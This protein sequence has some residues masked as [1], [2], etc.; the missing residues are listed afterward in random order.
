M[1]LDVPIIEII[2]NKVSVTELTVGRDRNHRE[3]HMG[4]ISDTPTL[5]KCPPSML[6]CR[7]SRTTIRT[8]PGTLVGDYKCLNMKDTLV[9]PSLRT[10]FL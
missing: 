6:L 5:E 8:A 1:R 3:W 2:I 7:G 10:F 4:T 9:R